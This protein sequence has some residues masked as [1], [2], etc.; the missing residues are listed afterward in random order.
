M[1]DETLLDSSPSRA[2]V[3]KGMHWLIGIAVGVV[4][5]LVARFTPGLLAVEGTDLLVQSGILGVLTMCYV[6]VVCYVYA[7]ARHLGLNVWTWFF[8]ALLLNIVGFVIYLIYSA[9]KTDNWKRA[10]IPLAYMV[11]IVLIGVAI[12][13]PCSLRKRSPRRC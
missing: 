13:I 9:I 1:F 10:T 4:F 2:P 8:V 6:L 12:L 5:F 7:D 11:E 3:L